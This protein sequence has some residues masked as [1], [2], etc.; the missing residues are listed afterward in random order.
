MKLP[1]LFLA[2]L[3]LMGQGRADAQTS[4][5]L[6]HVVGPAM[7]T[8]AAAWGYADGQVA[9]AE[10]MCG[11]YAGTEISLLAPCFD[12]PSGSLKHP[13]GATGRAMFSGSIV[14]EAPADT[15]VLVQFRAWPAEF[16]SYEEAVASSSP[17]PP[18][19]M[20]AIVTAIPDRVIVEFPIQMGALWLSPV[21]EPSGLGLLALG[22]LG[23]AAGRRRGQFL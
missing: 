12:S 7:F 2:T 23:L 11:V 16:G 5:R 1:I 4:D 3:M 17:S 19:G 8:N 13:F 6:Y 15:P 22:G 10:F 21:P 9:G 14:L 18:V 20:S